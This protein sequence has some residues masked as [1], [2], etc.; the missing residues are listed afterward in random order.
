M[1]LLNDEQLRISDLLV[2]YAGGSNQIVH[3][4]LTK[5]GRSVVDLE[6]VM[7]EID[8]ELVAIEE[9]E[10]IRMKKQSSSMSPAKP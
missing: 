9:K 1:R 10:K 3:K 8:E 2:Q 6:T 5:P 4:V 7:K